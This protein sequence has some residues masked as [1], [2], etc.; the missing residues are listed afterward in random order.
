MRITRNIIALSMRGFFGEALHGPI[1]VDNNVFIANSGIATSEA[2]G[3]VFAHNLFAN[4]GAIQTNGNGIVCTYYAPGTMNGYMLNTNV[5]HFFLLNNLLR[6]TTLPNDVVNASLQ[7][8]H[9]ME[10]NATASIE[11]FSYTAG[12]HEV[13]VSFDFNP[14]GATGLSQITQAR[15]G[16]IP[17]A[18]E[19]IPCNVDSDFFGH[20]IVDGSAMAGPFQNLTAGHHSLTL[21]TADSNRFAGSHDATLSLL[22]VNGV[23][24]TLPSAATDTCEITVGDTTRVLIRATPT[25]AHAMVRG[26]FGQMVLAPGRNKFTITVVAEDDVTKRTYPLVVNV[27]EPEPEPDDIVSGITDQLQVPATLYPNPFS[28]EA[29]LAGA[30]GCTLQVLA[31]NG[32]VVHTQH[33]ASTEELIRLRRLPAGMYFFVLEKGG[34]TKTIKATKGE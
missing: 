28:G 25:D 16:V 23:N 10:G 30:E 21:W 26:Q 22:T 33:L 11:N 15:V 9:D 4:N 5:Q 19:G 13:S 34:K 31:A 27:P 1:L 2:T 18:N 3:I 14:T 29:H 7:R 8:T 12:P 6:G 20:P 17:N 32:E 24:V